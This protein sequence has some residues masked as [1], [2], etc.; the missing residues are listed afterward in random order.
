MKG[1]RILLIAAMVLLA[2]ALLSL[3]AVGRM[4]TPETSVLGYPDS[5]FDEQRQYA[6]VSQQLKEQIEAPVSQGQRLGTMTVRSG[7]QI[8]A[9]IPMVAQNAVDRLTLGDLI[10]LVLKQTAMAK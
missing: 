9:Q 7:E 3:V 6:S 10:V 1:K 5:F 2:A 4:V 8:L